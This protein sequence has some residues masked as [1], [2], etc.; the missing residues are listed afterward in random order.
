MQG[1]LSHQNQLRNA[2]S[3]PPDFVVIHRCANPTRIKTPTRD[4]CSL[5]L[6]LRSPAFAT[7][8]R[9]SC[10]LL[11]LLLLLRS[12][13]F[14]T[15]TRSTPTC[16]FKISRDFGKRPSL[17]DCWGALFVQC[18]INNAAS[19]HVSGFGVRL[20]PWVQSDFHSTLHIFYEESKQKGE[21]GSQLD[22]FL[23]FASG[24]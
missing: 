3:L 17:L 20:G 5:L 21:R 6:L 1:R 4:S 13:A 11:L 23:A 7:P 14:A 2:L 16:F 15:P 18:D 19:A 8:T 24:K 9:D 10:L 12:Q 22:L